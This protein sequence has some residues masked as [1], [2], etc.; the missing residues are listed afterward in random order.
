M[1]Q[2]DETYKDKT[3]KGS[4]FPGKPYDFNQKVILNPHIIKEYLPAFDR[5][6]PNATKGLK[7][8]LTIMAF[9]EGFSPKKNRAGV[10][11]GTRAYVNNNPGN[12]GNDDA[13]N[14]VK[15]ETLEHG[16]RK[17]QSFIQDIIDGR[18]K[19]FPM[20][21]LKVI[22]PT[23]SE[24]I[25]KNT[26]NYGMSPWLPGYEFTF[27]GQLDQ[28]VKIYSTG[29]RGG[30]SYL[31]TIISYFRANGIIITPESKIQDIIKAE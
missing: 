4:T 21:K 2:F 1:S 10:V 20:G 17:Q 6:I 28:Y 13:G 12:I 22:K 23:F 7:L 26:K 31:N 15:Y 24:E 9:K 27:T 8:L 18:R 19:A 25:A 16:I 30:N 14:N 3:I 29:A 5:A 11:V